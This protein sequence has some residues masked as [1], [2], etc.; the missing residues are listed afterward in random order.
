MKIDA[1]SSPPDA[2]QK[3]IQLATLSPLQYEKVRKAEAQ[4]LNFRPSILDELVEAKR[5]Q[6]RESELQGHAVALS[7]IEFWPHPVNGAGVLNEMANVFSRYVALRPGAPDTLAL[8]CPHAHAVK[9][10]LCSPRLNISSPDRGCG[11]TT[12]RDVLSLFVPRPIPTEN[13]SVAVLFRLVDGYAP[14]ILADEYDSWLRDNEELRG[15]LNAGHRRGAMV[16]RCEGD[17]NEVRGFRAYAPAVLCGIGTLTVTLHERSIVIRLERAKLGELQ[18]RFDS[19]RTQNEQNLCRQLARWCADNFVRLES[20]DPT[21]P[22][23]VFNRLADNWRPLFAVAE[24]AGGDWPRRC[25]EAFAKLATY[26][27]A[28][29]ESLGVLLLGDIRQLLGGVYSDSEDELIG[30]DERIFSKDLVERLRAMNDRPWPEAQRGRPIT[31]RWLARLLGR[32]GIHPKTLR[33][34]SD[35]AK[36]YEARD[37]EEVFERYVPDSVQFKRDAVTCK[38]ETGSTSVTP[39]SIVTDREMPSIDAMSRCHGQKA[40]VEELI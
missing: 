33:I 4:R 26:Q 13:M 11:K 8:W 19:R 37:F 29:T 5:P 30:P 18:A 3:I 1:T 12:L 7:D 23:G 6:K 31:E 2:E 40:V 34:G 39:D 17:A 38:S 14:T 24:I 28:E 9:A 35:R 21:L 22:D 25:A 27:E 36:G 20:A 16:Y 10:F 15:L 32:F